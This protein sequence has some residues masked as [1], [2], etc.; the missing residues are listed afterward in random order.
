LSR[1]AKLGTAHGRVEPATFARG[2]GHKTNTIEVTHLTVLV[3][4][5]SSSSGKGEAERPNENSQH[6]QTCDEV[7]DNMKLDNV[8][9]DARCGGD[10][11]KRPLSLTLKPSYFWSPRETTAKQ[12]PTPPVASFVYPP[13]DVGIIIARLDPPPRTWC[14]ITMSEMNYTLLT[15]AELRVAEVSEI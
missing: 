11:E 12:N 14:L 13:A 9:R 1:L 5:R 3:L 8:H 4:S 15:G 6:S 7:F 10:K 2:L